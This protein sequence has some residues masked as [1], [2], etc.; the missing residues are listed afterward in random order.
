MEDLLNEIIRRLARIERDLSKAEQNSGELLTVKEAATLLKISTSRLY[1]LTSS[2]K[3]PTI[4]NR[5]IGKLY[6]KK[7]ELLKWLAE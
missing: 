3:I 1:Q 7:N 4:R 2:D 5:A 6:F